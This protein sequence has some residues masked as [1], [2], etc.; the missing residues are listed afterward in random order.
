MSDLNSQQNLFLKKRTITDKTLIKKFDTEFDYNFFFPKHEGKGVDVLIVKGKVYTKSKDK[1]GELRP[2]LVAVNPNDPFRNH[3]KFRIHGRIIDGKHKWLDSDNQK[4]RWSVD[5]VFV[6]DYD[7]FVDIWLNNEISKSEQTKNIQLRQRMED[8]CELLWEQKPIEI[9]DSNGIPQKRK[10]SP[11]VIKKFEGQKLRNGFYRY[12]PRQYVALKKI[13]KSKSKTKYQSK[14]DL[15]HYKTIQERDNLLKINAELESRAKP[16]S[17]KDQII[18]EKDRQIYRLKLCNS[19]VKSYI[20][21]ERRK[22]KLDAT[23]K[24]F[25]IFWSRFE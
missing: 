4:K 24:D 6:K 21:T 14:K 3:P 20:K 15:E 13:N 16:D 18:R 10:I 1:I 12:I 25:E 2:I 23:D 11:L 7:E 9:F 8:Y 19:N 17:E 22:K 5:Y